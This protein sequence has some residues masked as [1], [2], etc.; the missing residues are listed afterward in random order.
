[1]FVAHLDEHGFDALSPFNRG[2][3]DDRLDAG[4]ALLLAFDELDFLDVL[5]AAFP[6]IGV[7]FEENHRLDIELAAVPPVVFDV[8]GV[9]EKLAS[10]ESRVF[11]PG[12]VPDMQMRVDDREVR[13]QRVSLKLASTGKRQA[14]ARRGVAQIDEA[15]LG[16]RL[17]VENVPE[18]LVADFD[19][20]LGE[21]FRDRPGI[22][23]HGDVVV[24]HLAGMR[25]DQNVVRL[26]PLCV[27]GESCCRIELR[28]RNG[29]ALRASACRPS[30]W[31]PPM[32]ASFTARWPR[33]IPTP[34]CRPHGMRVCAT[35]TPRPGMDADFPN[36]GSAGSCAPSSATS[37]S[38][39]PRSAANSPAR[40]TPRPSTARHGWAGS[41]SRPSGTIPMTGSCGPMSRRCSAWRS[42]RSMRW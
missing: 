25:D 12:L 8:V 11:E 35:T 4:I 21:V 30:A 29:S 41:I 3:W 9:A 40:K 2:H 22:A 7:T 18:E 32:W 27:R 16:N 6:E 26:P 33:P 19:R 39:R 10:L 1:M 17:A 14:E 36:T 15:V 34:R 38:S 31:V 37:S 24:V 28:A 23:R 5:T 20:N 13:H 42:T